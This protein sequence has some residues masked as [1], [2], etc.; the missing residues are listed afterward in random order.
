MMGERVDLVTYLYHGNL[1]TLFRFQI[2]HQC[3]GI[4]IS[5]E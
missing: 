1:G 5:A 4:S 3:S 2:L